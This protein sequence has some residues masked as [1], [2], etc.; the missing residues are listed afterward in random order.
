MRNVKGGV[1]TSLKVWFQRLG[2][3]EVCWVVGDT[4]NPLGKEQ[5]PCGVQ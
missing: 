5:E 3:G 1:Q 2:D 4:P